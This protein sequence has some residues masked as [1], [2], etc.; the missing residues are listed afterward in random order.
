MDTS[1]TNNN[2][3]EMSNWSPD[4]IVIGPGGVKGFIELGALRR[5]EKSINFKNVKYWTGCSIGAAIAL[6]LVIGYSVKEIIEICQDINILPDITD[7]NINEITK[8]IG[9]IN[10]SSIQKKLEDKVIE[11]YGILLS[12]RQLYMATDKILT[13]VTYNLDDDRTE[14][15]SKDTEPNISCINAVM[16]SMS[17][18]VI[19]QS[20][21]Y[22]GRD[23]IDG[24]L[25]NPYPVDIHDDG[26]KT[27]LGICI[28]NEKSNN[29]NL[30]QKVSKMLNASIN[31]NRERI[32]K[33]STD[34]CYHLIL[35]SPIILDSIGVTVPIEHRR[36]MILSGYNETCIFLDKI[37]NPEKYKRLDNDDEEIPFLNSEDDQ[38]N[39]LN[40]INTINDISGNDGNNGIDEIPEIY[41]DDV[42]EYVASDESPTTSVLDL[43]IE[44]GNATLLP[45]L[46][47]KNK[48]EDP[49]Y[50]IIPLTPR[51][52][53]TAQSIQSLYQKQQDNR[54]SYFR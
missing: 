18:P 35:T 27:I 13:T 30:F 40:V 4:V 36:Q 38:Y 45:N 7:I 33:F 19:V 16:M 9:L 48:K 2:N 43:L 32:I 5:L 6:L 20:K 10:L 49:K 12:L 8:K 51:S 42:D 21:R 23:Y 41:D 52:Q 50:L 26:S 34:K 53:S 24:A 15:F 54:D 14:Y 28:I 46:P 17:I 29:T 31:Q 37:Y 11:K 47:K 25:G 44:N 39:D 3:N 22:K 1:L